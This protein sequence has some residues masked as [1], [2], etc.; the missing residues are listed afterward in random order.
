MISKERFLMAINHQ[1]PDRPPFNFWMDR[2]MMAD[3]EKEFGHRH[4][5]VLNYGADVIETFAELNWP[6]GP[7][8]EKYGTTWVTE[9]LFESWD[10]IDIDKLPLPDPYSE[11][12][13]ELIRR[14]VEE[15]P[16]VAVILALPTPFGMIANMRTF[17]NIYI[18][19]IQH[20]DEY[21]RLASRISNIYDIVVEKACEIGITAFYPMED[22]AN[23]NGL[24]M[25][26]EM[27]N[28]VC[29]N[30]SASQMEI[31]KSHNIPIL[32]HCCGKSMDLI[33]QLLPLGVKAFNPLQ[34]H[35]NNLNEFKQKYGKSI[36]LYGG[37]DN[38]F[39]I[40]KG[41]PE[42]IRQHVLDVFNIVGKKDGGL[43]FSTHDIS[44][45]T[46]AENIEMM[47]KT[48]KQECFY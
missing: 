35:L 34:P 7:A 8:V 12:V 47:V 27:I 29:L 28:E 21:K 48:I 5:R 4:W 1:K 2:R 39:T 38:S 23:A 20:R 45:D 17:N 6:K 3:Y 41:N 40:A 11:D 32:F 26:P 9:P 19:L 42:Q 30:Y 33:D 43:I 22:V 18:D 16:D 13:Y 14:D 24:S 25:S 15:F 46:P 36:A 37:L 44:I 10:D 31:A